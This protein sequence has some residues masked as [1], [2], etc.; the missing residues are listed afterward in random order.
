MEP[1]HFKRDEVMEER[2]R[3]PRIKEENEA[4]I[5]VVSGGKNLPEEEVARAIM[6]NAKRVFTF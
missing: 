4:T 5:K 6:A 3:A 2:R 1:E